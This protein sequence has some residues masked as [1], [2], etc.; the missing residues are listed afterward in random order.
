MKKILVTGGEG[1]IGSH[2]ANRLCELGHDVTVVDDSLFTNQGIKRNPLNKKIK[3]ID[4]DFSTVSILMGE[5]CEQFDVIYHLAASINVDESIQKPREYFDNNFDGTC[6]LIDEIRNYQK[7]CKFIYASSAEVYGTARAN[8]IREDHTLDP[9]SPYAVSKLATEQML[10]VYAQL[11]G[12]DITIIRNFNTFGEYQRGDFY[13]G[14]ISKF[15]NIALQGGDLPVYG[16]G[17]Q[18]RDYMH[19]SQAVEGYILAMEKK[20]PLIVNFGSGTPIRIID[21]AN[22]IAESFGVKIKHEKPRPN[23]IMRLEADIGRAKEYGYVVNTDFW[24][25]LKEYLKFI[26]NNSK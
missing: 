12:M 3:V 6:R 25:Q 13:G 11:Y 2:L 23:E 16:S 17:E 26:K 21:I 8:K 9:L 22:F 14:V 24:V 15:A 20:L 18:M 10:K 5:D 19:I 1:F 4:A 7:N